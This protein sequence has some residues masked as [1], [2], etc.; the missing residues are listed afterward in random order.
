MSEVP[1]ADMNNPS[2]TK[3]IFIAQDFISVNIMLAWQARP[4]SFM[5]GNMPDKVGGH[6][7]DM[8]VLIG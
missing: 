8:P 7:T 5:V 4:I 3:N 1:K 2:I 6:V